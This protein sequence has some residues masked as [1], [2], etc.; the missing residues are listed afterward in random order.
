MIR[1]ILTILV[2]SSILGCYAAGELATEACCGLAAP[3]I[4]QAPIAA[5]GNLGK[6][7]VQSLQSPTSEL[8]ENFSSQA[9][10]IVVGK[11]VERAR[12]EFTPI[13][14]ASLKQH[15][16]FK[17]RVEKC[18]KGQAA[19][20]LFLR[21]NQGDL[22]FTGPNGQYSGTRSDDEP[23]LSVGKTYVLFLWNPLFEKPGASPRP[24]TGSVSGVTGTTG[25]SNELLIL[26]GSKGVLE[27]SSGTLRLP[28]D[29]TARDVEAFAFSDIGRPLAGLSLDAAVMY[30]GSAMRDFERSVAR[31]KAI[32]DRQRQGGG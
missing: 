16:V 30:I 10:S 11:I 6:M 31:N 27:V 18:L 9:Q 4:S 29:G 28:D 17:V 21:K 13:G 14:A 7:R 12:Q 20:I 24:V 19:A 32:L 8:L 26:G 3:P 23:M 25:Y 15:T 5:K 22:P 2:S 1:L